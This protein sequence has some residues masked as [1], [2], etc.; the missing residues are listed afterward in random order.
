MGIEIFAISG[1]PFA[2]R[3]QLALEV[4]GVPYVT[5]ILERSK[6]EHRAPEYLAIN[7]RGRVPTLRDGDTVV[8][9]SIAILA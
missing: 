8:C 1:S 5:R 7:P 9:E 3:V 4:K 6:G 2:W